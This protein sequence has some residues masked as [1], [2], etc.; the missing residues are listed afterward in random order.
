[1][2]RTLAA[3]VV[4][5]ADG[6]WFASTESCNGHRAQFLVVAD[7]SQCT[8]PIKRDFHLPDGA[9][10]IELHA[11]HIR[12]AIRAVAAEFQE[13]EEVLV[14]VIEYATMPRSK[15]TAFHVGG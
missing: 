5:V 10:I 2:L 1:M 15:D 13:S 8:D 4:E 9:V 12:L 7:G 3:P 14:A 11:V 6:M